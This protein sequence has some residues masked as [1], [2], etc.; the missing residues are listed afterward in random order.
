MGWLRKNKGPDVVDLSDMQKRG[1]LPKP[2]PE[3]NEAGVVDLSSKRDSSSSGNFDFLGHLAGA[4]IG[5]TGDSSIVSDLRPSP[6]PVI[7]SLRSA[8]QRGQL[9]SDINEMRLKM[10]DNEFKLSSLIEKI[11]EIESRIDEIERG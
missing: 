9:N 8:R 11:K 2:T 6:G 4:G 10:D 3:K 5:E 1:L 7:S